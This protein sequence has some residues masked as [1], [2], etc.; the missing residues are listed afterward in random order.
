MN[1]PPGRVDKGAVTSW[2]RSDPTLPMVI[3]Q[4]VGE[5]A[6]SSK[7]LGSRIAQL[8][9]NTGNPS[10][11]LYRYGAVLFRD[12]R[13]DS[14][15]RLEEVLQEISHE[16]L[17]YVGGSS[18]RTKVSAGIYTSTEYP[19]QYDIAL[20]NEMSYCASWPRFLLFCCVTP[21]VSGGQTPLIR[22]RLLLERLPSQL[23]DE[24]RLKGVRYIRNLH[25]GVG[26]GKSW[27][28]TFESNDM[29]YVES[30]ARKAGANVSWN[31]DGSVTISSVQPATVWHPVTGEEVW[32]NQADLSHPSTLPPELSEA[33][34]GLFRG[35]E[36]LLPEFV[37]FGD[38]SPISPDYL[39]TIRSIT[40]ANRVAFDWRRGDLLL[41]DN[42]LVAHGRTAFHG[43]R[44]I[45]VTMLA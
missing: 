20:H 16:S 28:A 14:Q 30:E 24:F 4:D 15:S 36:H 21:S 40:S 26:Y 33:L 8:I 2:I 13:I 27:Q 35:R 22:S 39:G 10:D 18:P 19:A 1:T 45:L 44:R 11:A 17:D 41:V 29:Q 7:L 32:F 3:H 23:V 25:G 37:E 9:G 42:V 31:S 43:P 5:T 12:F 34:L 38:G 6:P